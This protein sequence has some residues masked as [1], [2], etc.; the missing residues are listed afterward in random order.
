MQENVNT[1]PLEEEYTDVETD[2]IKCKGCGSN[3][4]FDPE[5]QQ[6]KCAYCGY[7]EDFE[8]SAAVAE[9]AIEEA[10]RKNPTW[11]DDTIVYS[12]ENCGA[13]VVAGKGETAGLCPFCGTSH[14]V[15]KQDLQGLKPTAVVPFTINKDDAVSR[16]IKWAKK[17]I[18]AP[19]DFKR[20]VRS[21][22]ITGL[23]APYFTFD[24]RT[25]SVYFG[26]V[27]DRRTRTVRTKDGTK[28]ETYIVW[29]HI[30]GTYRDFFDDVLVDAG[31]RTDDKRMRKIQPFDLTT[32]RVYANE[33][34]S[35]FV[36]YR[37]DKD[38]TTCWGE[39]KQRMES[40][41]RSRI[42]AMHHCDVV[43]YVNV[44]TSHEGVTFK[45]TLLPVYIINYSHKQKSYTTYINGTT[46]KI[47]G[48]TPVCWWKA[49]LFYGGIA[50]AVAGVA[51][52]IALLNS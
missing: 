27:G 21:E 52:L 9:L 30:R 24:S 35:G 25:T 43:D 40:M 7:T 2:S 44:T 1:T 50:L 4:T 32:T 49:L 47:S 18:L 22:K 16:F 31:Q 48:K 26:R 8:K 20:T 34:L 45:Y 3:L 13:R 17:K 37:Y 51:V 46:G 28:T 14:V 29:R 12:C 23:Y 42:I 10:L 36:A 39:A 41:I 11:S 19:G 6:L 5:T 38:I 33:F 15:A